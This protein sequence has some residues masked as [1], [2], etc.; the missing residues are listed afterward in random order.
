MSDIK[1]SDYESVYR[2]YDYPPE[3]RRIAALRVR[4]LMKFNLVQTQS[5]ARLLESAYLQGIVDAAES[6][7]QAA[8]K[9]SRGE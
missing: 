9:F 6:L 4:G 7:P 3:M 8:D 1:A 2:H 5:M